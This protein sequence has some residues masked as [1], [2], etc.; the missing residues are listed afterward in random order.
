MHREIEYYYM[1]MKSDLAE[2]DSNQKA[3][4][5]KKDDEIKRIISKII[6]SIADLK[7]LLGTNNICEMKNSDYCTQM[8][9][10]PYR[11]FRLRR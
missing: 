3:I 9:P 11:S 2:I 5:L 1:E 10:S 6:E 4:F 7:K 8:F